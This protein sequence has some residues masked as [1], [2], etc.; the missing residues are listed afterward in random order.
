MIKIV[1]VYILCIL[2]AGNIYGQ[3]ESSLLWKLSG[4]GIND[5][6][7]FGTI[8]LL[9]AEDLSLSDELKSSLASTRQL[10]LELDFDDPSLMTEVQKYMVMEDQSL[11]DIVSEDEY[12]LIKT[13]FEEK[14][15]M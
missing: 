2:I 5:S 9:C 11:K 15:G 7:I 3:A 10:V 12:A 4:E 1:H 13:F 8:H 6:Y 14:M